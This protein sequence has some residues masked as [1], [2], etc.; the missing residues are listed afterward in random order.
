[1]VDFSSQTIPDFQLIFIVPN[2]ETAFFQLF[3]EWLD[4]IFF[5]F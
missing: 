4:H 3:R 5:V 2:F 1:M